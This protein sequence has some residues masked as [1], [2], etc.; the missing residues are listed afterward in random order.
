MAN[1]ILKFAPNGT[2]SDLLT[3]GEYNADADRLVGN[4]AGIARRKLVN[5]VLRQCAFISN[6]FAEYLISKVGGDVLD[7]NDTTALVAKITAAF[8]YTFTN[9]NN[10]IN[11]NMDFWQRGTS[12]SVTATNTYTADRYVGVMA[13][14]TATVARQSTTGSESFNAKYFLRAAV[15][16]SVGISNFNQLA[17]RIE[18]VRRFS[19]K[20]LTLSFWAKADSARNMSVEF[21]QN[22]G[23]GGS[24]SA[25]VNALGVQKL[26]LTTSWQK[27]TKTVTLPSIAGK[28]IGSDVNSYLALNFWFDAGSNYNSRTD[29][30]GQQSGTFDI[31]QVK[32]EEGINATDFVLAG[33]TI[34]GE[35][36][37][38]Q[39]Y[40]ELTGEIQLSMVATVASGQSVSQGVQYKVTKRAT[41]NRV[42]LTDNATAGAGPA[43]FS[44]VTAE[45]LV[46]AFTATATGASSRR[47]TLSLES[48]L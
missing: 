25:D 38:C 7:N 33:G 42:T 27:F 1:D 34:Q 5:K 23:T 32:L 12:V 46:Y 24:P 22:F 10:I 9:A 14:S 44:N 26:A 2:T 18:D 4:Q 11:G 43:N 6:G 21:V 8:T 29:S 16:S 19:G 47:V 30:L 31:A 37:A 45:G 35:L 39:R 48:E 17:Q 13:G 41:P 15:T 36:A 40:F 3:Q 20:T 28:V